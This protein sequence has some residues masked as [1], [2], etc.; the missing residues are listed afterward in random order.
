VWPYEVLLLPH[1]HVLRIFDLDDTQREALA[2]LLKQVMTR[3]DNLFETPFPYTMGWHGAPFH[4]GQDAAWQLHAHIYPPLLRSATIRK[5]M[6]GYEML[7]EPQRDITPES[8]AGRL[9]ELSDIH[10]AEKN[11]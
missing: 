8:A 10:Y 5:F 1:Q 6:V 11:P 4:T 2:A 9:R 7:A 3:L